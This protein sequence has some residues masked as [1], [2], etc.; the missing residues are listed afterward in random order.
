MRFPFTPPGGSAEMVFSV[1]NPGGA[2]LNGLTIIIDG[3][4]AA[5]FYITSALAPALAPGGAASFTL[6]HAPVT[7]GSKTAV[8]HIASN[9]P[10]TRNPFDITLRMVPGMTEEFFSPVTGTVTSI[11][12]HGNGKILAGGRESIICLNADGSPDLS[13]FAP[14]VAGGFVYSMAVQKDGR[15]LMG[16]D[17]ERVG[18]QNRPGLARLLPDGSLD[19]TFISEPFE[20]VDCLAVQPNGKILAGGDFTVTGE[21]PH[22]YLV[23][24]NAD[25]S[26][27]NGFNPVPNQRIHCVALQPDGKILIGGRFSEISSIPADRIARLNPDG[28]PDTFYTDFERDVQCLSVQPDGRILAGGSFPGGIARL[29]PDGTR[30]PSM[31][32]TANGDVYGLALQADGRCLVAGLFNAFGGSPRY[33]LARINSG[34][35]LDEDFNAW[36][37]PRLSVWRLTLQQDGKVL[38]FGDISDTGDIA[39][40]HLTRLEN[41]PAFSSLTNEGRSTVHWRRSGSSPEIS[42]VTFDLKPDDSAEWTPLGPGTRVTGGWKLTGLT[43]PSSGT[44]R[45]QARAGGSVIEAVNRILTPLESWRLQYFNTT[46]NTVD[47]ADDADPDHDGLTNFI[48]FAFGLSP[49]DRTVN[50]A[51]E[52]TLQGAFFTSAFTS[53]ENREDVIYSAEWSATMDAGTW[54]NIPDEGDGAAHLFRVPA[55]AERIFARW[56]VK[57]R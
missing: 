9:V 11:V 13:F 7:T 57:M 46:A 51:P 47:A 41:D 32:V 26:V 14:P 10:G 30:D 52:F 45:A 5:E 16:G 36:S 17:F 35:T 50:D 34:G 25:G 27:D 43:L 49:V 44:L 54:K 53:P 3:P 1:R 21:T 4:D 56:I 33:G 24:L 29:L 40:L 20:A 22:R 31:A 28:T 42:D 55:G 15:I 2:I 8:L 6:R 48:E 39:Q 37:S 38:L 12:V 23:R 19:L 18:G